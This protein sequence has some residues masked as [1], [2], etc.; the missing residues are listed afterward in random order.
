MKSTNKNLIK[1]YC[2]KETENVLKT[3][4]EQVKSNGEF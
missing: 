4:V 2:K 3:N 1:F